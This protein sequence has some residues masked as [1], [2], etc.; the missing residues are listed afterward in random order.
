MK[1]GYGYKLFEEN[2]NGKLFPLFIGKNEEVE[3]G[4]WVH[5]ENIPTNGFAARPGWHI[6][7]DVPDAPWLKGYDGTDVG[8][9]NSRFK[10]GKRVWCLVSYNATNCYDSEVK[11]LTKKCF[12]DKIPED[13][14][15]FFKEAGKGV[16]C[17]TSDI[18]IIRKISEDER[19]EI[20]K[21]K[22]YDEINAYKKYKTS[23]EKRINKER[24]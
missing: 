19:L 20:L 15:Y 8:Y 11:L 22:G 6:G 17:I 7:M 18:K 13:G 21:E 2:E 5:A 23:L 24:R 1:I 14:Y 9:Y 16:W 10:N 12:M 3:I 4:K